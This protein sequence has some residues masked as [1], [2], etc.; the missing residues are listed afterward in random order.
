MDINGFGTRRG[1]LKAGVAIA[2][3]TASGGV[4]AACSKTAETAPATPA[5]PAAP[6]ATTKYGQVKGFV[7]DGISGF[8]GVRYGADTGKNR[9]GPPAA[10]EPWTDVKDAIDYGAS[11]PQNPRRRR[12]R[13]VQILASATRSAARRGLPLP[14]RLDTGGRRQETAGHGLVPRRRLQHGLGLV[15]GL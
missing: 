13:T 4:L 7:E 12:R 8:K 10:P 15:A 14:Q 1:M 3:L 9:F 6:V 11:T 2:A 5:A